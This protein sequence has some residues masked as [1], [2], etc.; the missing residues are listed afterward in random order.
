MV[1]RNTESLV[2]LVEYQ[3]EFAP[4]FDEIRNFMGDF[5]AGTFCS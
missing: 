3:E 5:E 2:G 1:G 4:F